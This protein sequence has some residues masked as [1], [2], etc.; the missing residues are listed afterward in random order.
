MGKG[1][2]KFW[3]HQ[4]TVTPYLGTGTDGADVWGAPVTVAG[5]LQDDTKLVQSVD[6]S[7]L[8]SAGALFMCDVSNAGAFPLG[9]KVQLPMRVAHVI[10]V[11]TNDSGPLGLPD[12]TVVALD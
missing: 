5:W 6:A 3:I 9:S 7:E 10:G 4:V 8:V 1:L 2:A 11:N 12:H